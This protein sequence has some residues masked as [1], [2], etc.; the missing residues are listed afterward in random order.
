MSIIGDVVA[1]WCFNGDRVLATG[2]R[3]T[4]KFGLCLFS[5]RVFLFE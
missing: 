4:T 3:R 2:V 5:G 1:V